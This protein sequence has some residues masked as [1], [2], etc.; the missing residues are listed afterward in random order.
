MPSGPQ[1]DQVAAAG[2]REKTRRDQALREVAA[3]W[4]TLTA[5]PGDD[6]SGWGTHCACLPSYNRLLMSQFVHLLLWYSCIGCCG[7]ISDGGEKICEMVWDGAVACVLQLC[8]AVM[9][10]PSAGTHSWAA[11]VVIAAHSLLAPQPCSVRLRAGQH[12][13]CAAVAWHGPCVRAAVMHVL[14]LAGAHGKLHAGSALSMAEP[15]RHRA[16]P[17]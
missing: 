13:W 9:L 4:L 17:A 12:Q 16:D 1:R 3:Q 14:L 7:L 2:S 6:T 15:M 8:P 10:S 11:P 5:C